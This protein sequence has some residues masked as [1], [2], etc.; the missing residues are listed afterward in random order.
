MDY[1]LLKYPN[2]AKQFFELNSIID[3]PSFKKMLDSYKT[4]I[5][6]L[7]YNFLIKGHEYTKP[8]LEELFF[9][10]QLIPKQKIQYQ[11]INDNF[12]NFESKRKTINGKK[13]TVY[14][15]Y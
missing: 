15:F 12:D 11:F 6:E 1:R 10:K 7:A 4:E 14:K 2:V 13:Y 5:E 8:E 9:T 3:I